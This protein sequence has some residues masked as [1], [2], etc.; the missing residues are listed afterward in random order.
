MKH[1]LWVVFTYFVAT[2][3]NRFGVEE[4]KLGANAF[5]IDLKTHVQNQVKTDAKT[6]TEVRYVGSQKQA[7]INGVWE[8]K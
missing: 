5:L 4:F 7:L 8:N 2:S 1:F 3:I 6:V